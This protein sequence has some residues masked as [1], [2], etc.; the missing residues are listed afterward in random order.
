MMPEK[1]V[2]AVT[3]DE[4]ELIISIGETGYKLA[5]RMKIST[6]A[7]Y[8]RLRGETPNDMETMNHGSGQQQHFF[9]RVIEIGGNDD[10]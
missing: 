9:I 10:E 1:L 2:L 5:K 3:P 4:Y 7:I 6:T 8:K